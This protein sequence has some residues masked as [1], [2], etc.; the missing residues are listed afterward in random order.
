MMAVLME[1]KQKDMIGLEE[2]QV[3]KLNNPNF[4]KVI[5]LAANSS[6][7]ECG[8]GIEKWQDA[9]PDLVHRG[10]QIMKY[11]GMLHQFIKPER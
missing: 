6:L 9:N 5:M 3:V 11:K 4:N 2:H 10:N 1:S 8:I 7:P